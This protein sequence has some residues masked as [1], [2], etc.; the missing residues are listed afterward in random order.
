MT[1]G[2]ARW[3]ALAAAAALLALFGIGQVVLSGVGDVSPA[4]IRWRYAAL[5]GACM[6]ALV[7]VQACSW[8]LLMCSLERRRV[9]FWS[10]VRLFA[11]TWPGR[12]VPGSIPHYGGRLAAAHSVGL[13]RAGVAASLVY[14]NLIVLV[15]GGAVS[16]A[17][18]LFGARDALGA[19]AAAPVAAAAVVLALFALHPAVVRRIVRLA[20]RRIARLGALEGHV[21]PFRDVLRATLA[22]GAGT[23][24]IGVAFWSALA[25][26]GASGEA[27]L[28]LALAAYN[29][30]GVVGM[31]AVA[32]PG[33]L[34]VREGVTVALLGGSV[35]PE[36]ALS[37]AVVVRLAGVV[38][39]LV[40]LIMVLASGAFVRWRRAA[41]PGSSAQEYSETH[42]A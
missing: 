36:T 14:E 20:A 28:L 15:A 40:P 37:A 12:Y 39:D 22:Y 41:T 24:C 8:W 19:S 7:V 1:R 3:Y 21:L 2:N 9:R 30:A 32:I 26:V 23:A 42:A 13:S 18:L 16:I 11:V 34:G 31:L 17:L 38:A 35:S 10:C 27:P 29:L 6:L 33:G 4:E 5:S 25:A